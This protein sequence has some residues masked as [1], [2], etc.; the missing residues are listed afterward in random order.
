MKYLKSNDILS[1]IGIRSL[2]ILS[3]NDDEIV[4][5]TSINNLSKLIELLDEQI[6]TR[7]FC[8]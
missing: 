7:H 2:E 5:Q 4:R 3:G 1:F 8:F 6:T